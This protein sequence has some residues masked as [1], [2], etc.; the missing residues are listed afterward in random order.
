[1]NIMELAFEVHP[2]EE[3]FVPRK[4]KELMESITDI[5]KEVPMVSEVEMTDTTWADK[6]E[7]EV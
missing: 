1:M 2:D 3:S 6:K 4:I 7:V 5:I